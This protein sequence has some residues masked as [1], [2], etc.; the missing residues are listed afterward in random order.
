ME[1]F[2]NPPK[3]ILFHLAL[4]DTRYGMYSGYPISQSFFCI[5]WSESPS[6]MLRQVLLHHGIH[7]TVQRRRRL[8]GGASTL[9]PPLQSE[10]P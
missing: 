7:K 10:S 5:R 8:H 6:L 9:P 2:K 4:K 1:P 3:K